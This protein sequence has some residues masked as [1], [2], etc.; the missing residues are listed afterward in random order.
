MS[1]RFGQKLPETLFLASR[2]GVTPGKRT[3]SCP[4][5][6]VFSVNSVNPDS[7]KNRPKRQQNKKP[8][9]LLAQTGFLTSDF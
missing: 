7:D 8:V 9:W 6:S 4:H 2:R 1:C 5:N 3:G